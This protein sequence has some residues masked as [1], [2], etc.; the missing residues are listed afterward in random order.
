MGAGRIIGR[1]IGGAAQ[2]WWYQVHPAT[3]HVTDVGELL[4]LWGNHIER[5][6][7]EGTDRA[8]VSE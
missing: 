1:V 5:R 8:S 4:L 7:G 6:I 3:D 2:D